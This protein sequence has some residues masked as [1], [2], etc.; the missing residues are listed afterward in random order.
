MYKQKEQFS[1]VNIQ[2]SNLHAHIYFARIF[3]SWSHQLIAL[4]V[5][6]PQYSNT[7]VMNSQWPKSQKNWTFGIFYLLSNG[8][9]PSKVWT[10]WTNISTVVFPNTITPVGDQHEDPIQPRFVEFCGIRYAW[11]CWREPQK[12]NNKKHVAS[13]YGGILRIPQRGSEFS[14]LS[15]KNSS[16]GRAEIPA[17]HQRKQFPEI[18]VKVRLSRGYFINVI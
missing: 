15:W 10:S 2:Q 6:S 17:S 1:T 14:L 12:F 7:E 5:T 16:L 3:L 9:V 4:Q 18:S 8:Y 11:L 13:P